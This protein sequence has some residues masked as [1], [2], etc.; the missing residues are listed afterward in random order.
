MSTH[1]SAYDI[2]LRLALAFI[3][4]GGLIGF[5]RDERGHSAGLRTNLL[6]CLAAFHL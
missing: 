5:D 6:V 1:V 2:C 4:E 3:A